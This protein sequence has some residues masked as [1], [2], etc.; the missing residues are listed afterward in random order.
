MV[1]QYYNFLFTGREDQISELKKFGTDFNLSYDMKNKEAEI[2]KQIQVVNNRNKSPPTMQ[3]PP[4]AGE[5]NVLTIVPTQSKHATSTPNSQQPMPSSQ[6]PTTHATAVSPAN[7][8]AAIPTTQVGM[9]PQHPAHVMP[10]QPQPPYQPNHPAQLHLPPRDQVLITQH[11][12][13]AQLSPAVQSHPSLPQRT[14]LPDK[15]QPKQSH[16]MHMQ[17]PSPAQ[18]SVP[19][20]P[21]HAG[22]QNKAV[23]TQTPP[24]VQNVHTQNVMSPSQHQPPSSQSVAQNAQQSN[25]SCV[26]QRSPPQSQN[27]KNAGQ[28]NQSHSLSPSPTASEHG[29]SEADGNAKNASKEHDE[30]LDDVTSTLKKS[31]LNPNAK[32]FV[33]N[34]APKSFTPLSVSIWCTPPSNSIVV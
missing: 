34:P 23:I 2:P 22:Q 21:Q 15:Q 10:Q 11:L 3:Q 16:Q 8:A 14:L 28:T 4:P 13:Q 7:M 29:S 33:Y 20:M 18:T 17:P 26:Q 5:R 30:E 1:I 12:A 31:T 19:S 25:T 24:N 9:K 27:I 32:E 6:P